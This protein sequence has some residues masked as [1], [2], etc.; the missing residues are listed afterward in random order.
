MAHIEVIIL[1]TKNVTSGFSFVLMG[2][3]ADWAAE[4]VKVILLTG[5]P[6]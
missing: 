3:A 6:L 2:I 1:L 5:K 4:I